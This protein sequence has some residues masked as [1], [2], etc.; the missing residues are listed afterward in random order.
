MKQVLLLVGT[1][2][3]LL[4]LGLSGVGGW[5]VA[6]TVRS[7]LFDA[8]A[9]GTVISHQTVIHRGRR[10][11][12]SGNQHLE[13]PTVRFTTEDGRQIEFQDP[14]GVS[15]SVRSGGTVRV[16]YR[17]EAPREARIASRQFSMSLLGGALFLL[18]LPVLAV[19]GLL[20]WLGARRTQDAAVPA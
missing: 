20:L 14:V 19:A 2:T 18:G 6:G 12:S 7:L 9:E 10:A 15:G 3:L 8:A 13:Y 5:L 1:F 16:W 4:G 11:R 17:P